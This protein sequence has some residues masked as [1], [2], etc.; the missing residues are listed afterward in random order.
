MKKLAKRP[1]NNVSQDE[2]LRLKNRDSFHDIPKGANEPP[3]YCRSQ[4]LAPVYGFRVKSVAH[5]RGGP[6]LGLLPCLEGLPLQP[7]GQEALQPG[8]PA[9]RTWWLPV[10][11][12][13]G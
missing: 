2:V 10:S 11:S 8:G 6:V 9:A 13:A 7:G 5:E 3:S 12:W 4:D 1:L